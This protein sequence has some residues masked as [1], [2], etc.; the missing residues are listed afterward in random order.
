MLILQWQTHL[1]LS[2]HKDYFRG[3]GLVQSIE[4]PTLD[5]GSGRDLRVMRSSPESGSTLSGESA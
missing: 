1:L 2:S 4:R 5:F 3:V